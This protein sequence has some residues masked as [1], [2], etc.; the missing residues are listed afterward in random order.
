MLDI[1]NM[2]RQYVITNQRLRG[3]HMTEAAII[4]YLASKGWQKLEDDWFSLKGACEQ[5]VC[6]EMAYHLQ[7]NLDRVAA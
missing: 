6:V 3:V 5:P 7:K 4:R 1:N 2:F